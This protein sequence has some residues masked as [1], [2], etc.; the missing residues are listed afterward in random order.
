MDSCSY[1][2]GTADYSSRRESYKEICSKDCNVFA[3][4]LNFKSLLITHM[5]SIR[6]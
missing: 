5:Q 6:Y 3:Y 4:V 2:I 1:L